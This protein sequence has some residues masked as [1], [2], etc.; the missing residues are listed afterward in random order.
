MIARAGTAVTIPVLF[1]SGHPDGVL[2]YK[3]Y[4]P[5]GV[6]L[7]SG[8]ITVPAD[9]V[10]ANIPVSSDRNVLPVGALLSYRDVEWSYLVNGEIINGE[11]RY[12]LE[13]R[14]P[15][16]VSN[17]GVRSKLG[18]EKKDLPDSDIS[19][20]KAFLAFQS[21]TP[22]P[23]AA[24]IDPVLTVTLG[25]AIEALAAIS[26]IPTMAVR[27]AVKESSG[28]NQYQRQ[29]VDWAAVQINLESLVSAGYLA[30]NPQYDETTNFGSLLLVVSPA[31][32]RFTGA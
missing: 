7:G 19:L 21:V 12:N 16:G 13:A 20:V 25:D 5:A 28:T 11:L 9:A 26:L 15:F 17:D 1:S 3:I 27:V 18:V 29:D 31:V 4:D 10:S 8:L 24:T 6:V 22:V 2:A 14:L 23:D 30:V 32:D